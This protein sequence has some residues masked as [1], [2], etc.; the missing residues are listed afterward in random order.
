MTFPCDLYRTGMRLSDLLCGGCPY[1]SRAQEQWSRFEYDIDD[2]VPLAIADM[3]IRKMMAGRV[4]RDVMRSNWCPGYSRDKL[5]TAQS[6]DPDIQP[7]V[8]WLETETPPTEEELALCVPALKYF[9]LNRNM[10]LNTGVLYQLWVREDQP[11]REL[12]IVPFS[13]RR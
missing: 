2:V 6:Q 7:M 9:W 5:R 10:F 12:L 1:C 8:R 11:V 13:L 3:C 4:E